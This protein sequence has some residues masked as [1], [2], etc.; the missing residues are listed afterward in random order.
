MAEPTRDSQLQVTGPTPFATASVKPCWRPW[1]RSHTTSVSTRGPS[2]LAIPEPTSVPLPV[3]SPLAPASPALHAAN[4][5]P[6]ASFRGGG[7]R[8]RPGPFVDAP[9]AGDQSAPPHVPRLRRAGAG[10]CAGI[11]TNPSTKRRHCCAGLSAGAWRVRHRRTYASLLDLR[12]YCRS[13]A[14]ATPPAPALRPWS[15]RAVD[16]RRPRDELCFGGGARGAIHAGASTAPSTA[17]GDESDDGI[18]PPACPARGAGRRDDAPIDTIAAR[19]RNA[20]TK[21]K[22]G[23]RGQARNRP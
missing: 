19:A 20:T 9:V 16:A 2:G 21:R 4:R 12:P 6:T 22:E 18:A 13:P 3:A 14:G 11:T 7:G 17:T 23:A 15:V 5:R 10:G 1:T 8:A